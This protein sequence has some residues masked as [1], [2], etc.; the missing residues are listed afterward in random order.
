MNPTIAESLPVISLVM[1]GF[2]L[3]KARVLNAEDGHLFSR[4]ILNIT[5]PA[6]IFL[7][8]SQADIEPLQLGILALSSFC[9]SMVL[10]VLS[11]NITRIL[12][13][14]DSIAGVVI[15][16]SMVMNIGTLLYP[17]IHTVYGTEGVSRVAAF[18]IGNSLMASG[19]GYYIATCYGTKNPCGIRNSLIKVF[20]VPILWATI[21]GLIVNLLG[22]TVPAFLIKMLT[23]VSAANTPLA[24]IALGVFVN[25]KFPKWKLV[26]LTVFL[27][28]GVG[29][30]L[31]L[32]IVFITN[33]QGLDR[34]V[35]IMGSAMPIGMVPLVYAAAEGLDTEFAA[36]CISLS[37][38]IGVIITPLL[39]LI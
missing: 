20:S 14:E 7:S 22:V 5:L 35:V 25:L 9:I 39:L 2:L 32:A 16:A 23:P 18:D 8:I 29:F 15:L 33:L 17:V 38:I 34:V 12:K 27:R 10:R 4:L 26:S 6:V 31:G 3:K 37:I 1:V 28:M 24:M 13:I 19:Y 21:I 36:A 11:G 30:L